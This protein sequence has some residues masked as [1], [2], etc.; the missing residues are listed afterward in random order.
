MLI[1]FNNQILYI[2]Y[3]KISNYLFIYEKPLKLLFV[4][5]AVN[6]LH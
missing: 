2:I 6:T 3:L 1:K 5:I 4:K